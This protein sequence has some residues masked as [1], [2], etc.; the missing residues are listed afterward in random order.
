MTSAA[1]TG[2]MAAN[3]H[4]AG[5][6]LKLPACSLTVFVPF[7][8]SAGLGACRGLSQQDVQAQQPRR[9]S[10]E[11]QE[12]LESLMAIL[13]ISSSAALRALDHLCEEAEYNFDLVALRICFFQAMSQPW[14][15]SASNL[16]LSGR[17]DT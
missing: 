13:D 10:Q 4:L 9:T 1:A 17:C 6:K 15:Y 2:T 5:E 3:E 7:L 8:G 16:K 11:Q 12:A 14:N